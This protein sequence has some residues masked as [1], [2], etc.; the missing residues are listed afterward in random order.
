[1][2]NSPALDIRAVW[3]AELRNEPLVQSWLWTGYLGPGI[4]TLLTSRAK[5]GKTTLL[6]ALLARLRT[7]GAVA[8][9]EVTTGKALVVSEEDE[10]R[11]HARARRFDFRG[12]VCLIC[13]PFRSKPAPQQWQALLDRILEMQREHQFALIVFDTLTELLPRKCE[14]DAGLMIDALLPLRALTAE[15]AAVLL[16]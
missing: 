11:W 14:N 1:M 8:G 13:R 6:A 5:C 16:Q 12:Q 2:D 9:Q 7:G 10:R 15:G 3:D 4:V